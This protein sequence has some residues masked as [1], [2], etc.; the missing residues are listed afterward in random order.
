[1]SRGPWVE[2]FTGRQFFILDPRPEDVHPFDVAH[3]LA[4]QCRYNGHTQS[5]YSVA[6]H[7]VLM[8]GWV[9]RNKNV[10]AL[11]AECLV[12]DA[13]EAY[14]GD[15]VTGVKALFP[16]FEEIEAEVMKAIREAFDMPPEISELYTM[17]VKQFDRRIVR[18]EAEALLKPHGPVR[19]RTLTRELLGVSIR[20]WIPREARA[21]YLLTM[22]KLLDLPR[23]AYHRNERKADGR[24]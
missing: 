10:R 1:M 18:D 16:G 24:A 2:T 21:Q 15:L 6:E 17:A 4:H 14:V 7:C 13:A 3:S 12:H 9:M 19:Q 22:K 11:A 5:H 20:K 23:E 8:A